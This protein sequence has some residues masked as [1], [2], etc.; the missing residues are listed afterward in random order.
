MQLRSWSARLKYRN[1]VSTIHADAGS[2][3]SGGWGSLNEFTNLLYDGKPIGILAGTGGVADELPEW[4][5]RQ[6]K[7]SDCGVRRTPSIGFNSSATRFRA[8]R[9]WLRCPLPDGLESPP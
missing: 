2:I 9:V 8:S 4:F 3:I 6:R 5:P 1:V 7:K